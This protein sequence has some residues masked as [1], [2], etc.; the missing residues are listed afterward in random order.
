MWIITKSVCSEELEPRQGLVPALP[1]VKIGYD[2]QVGRARK[3]EYAS[4]EPRTWNRDST[5][6]FMAPEATLNMR[7][8]G[9]RQYFY[10]IPESKKAMVDIEQVLELHRLKDKMASGVLGKV[11]N[12][13]LD[14]ARN[15]A[16]KIVSGNRRRYVD[17]YYDLDLTYI[18]QRIIAMAF[19]G[20]DTVGEFSNSVRNDMGIV[21]KFLQERHAG[22]YKIYNLCAEKTYSEQN[23]GGHVEWIPVLDHQPPTLRQLKVRVSVC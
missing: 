16:R 19:P 15:K 18:T 4:L 13:A 5:E 9:D 7:G 11:F 8:D 14:G 17:A 12:S 3:A 20:V 22:R 2:M 1:C 21:I 10:F 6:G 23:M